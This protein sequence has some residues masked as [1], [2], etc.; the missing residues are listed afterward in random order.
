MALGETHSKHRK[1]E[2]NMSKYILEEVIGE[3]LEQ[4]FID[5]PK[6]LYKDC[7]YWVCPLDGDIRGVFNTEKNRLFNGGEA[8]R[9]IAR[10]AEGKAVG[11]IAAFYNRE[12]AA[13]EEQPT[14]GCGFFESIDSQEVANL[15]FDKAKEWLIS[16][17]MEAMDGPVNFGSRDE[18]W[19]LLVE[20][21]E[22]KPLYANPYNPPYYQQLFENY[23]FKVYFNQHTYSRELVVNELN[24]RVYNRVKRLEESG[25]YHFRHITKEDFDTLPEIFRT[26]YNKAWAHFPGVRPF[27]KED[28][29]K[30]FNTMKLIIDPHLIYLAFHKGE[31][32]GFYIMVPDLNKG[33]GDFN[34][35][36][37]LFNTL[38]L[39]YRI[40]TKKLDRIFAIIFA[41]T[42]EYQ[43]RG[44][45]SGIINCFEQT[46][47]AGKCKQYK[48]MELAWMGDFNPVMMRMVESYVNA[49]RHKRHITYRLL[50][51]PNKEFKRCPRLMSAR[52]AAAKRA[53]EKEEQNN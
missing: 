37:N 6:K 23:G 2:Q 49:K 45:E 12:Q 42:P 26:I 48:E 35:K 30:M 7:K 53:A 43:G 39:L 24:E 28:T 47:K 41:V 1:A 17:G 51:D 36:L 9:W 19:G 29:Q 8:I 18:W 31:P 11:R 16:K 34:G 27:S 13:I 14:G 32:I 46:V 40:K 5:L 22:S 15:L 3:R 50:F 21:F 20:G 33:I 25:E 52:D 38:R 4:E 10:D 44:I